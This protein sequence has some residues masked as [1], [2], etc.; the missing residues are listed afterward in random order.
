MP[1]IAEPACPLPGVITSNEWRGYAREVPHEI[2]LTGEIFTQRIE[3][4]NLTLRVR[5]KPHQVLH[6]T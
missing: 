2:D 3:R 1:S 4:N 5:I 6:H